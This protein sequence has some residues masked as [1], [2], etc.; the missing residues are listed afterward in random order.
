[1]I[2]QILYTSLSES[3]RE[4]PDLAWVD[5]QRGQF[6]QDDHFPD[7]PLPALLIDVHAIEWADALMEQQ[8]G[9]LALSLDLYLPSYGDSEAEAN[10]LA[11]FA[12]ITQITRL[13]HNLSCDGLQGFS[14]RREERLNKLEHH[15]LV[16]YRLLFESRIC[17]S[18]ANTTTSTHTLKH[19]NTHGRIHQ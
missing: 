19:I 2:R 12:L 17:E 7:V 5:W 4:V 16:A 6:Q 1:M 18:L 15:N 14:R 9:L 13:M 8:E 10:T 11:F 3:L